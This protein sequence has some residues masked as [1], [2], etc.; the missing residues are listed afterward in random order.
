MEKYFAV[1][2]VPGDEHDLEEL[3]VRTAVKVYVA[4]AGARIT[5]RRRLVLH[6]QGGS[7]IR[8]WNAASWRTFYLVVQVRDCETA[9][10]NPYPLRL[11]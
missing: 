4:A 5:L 7:C 6:D 9:A 2:V 10:E 11:R 8:G 1:E 3:L